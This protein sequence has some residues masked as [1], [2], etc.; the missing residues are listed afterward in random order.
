M[1]TA[2]R[3]MQ[4]IDELFKIFR[5]LGTPDETTWPGVSRYPDYKDTFP[6]W[7]ARNL[8]ELVPTLEPAGIDVLSLMLRRGIVLPKGFESTD[9]H[10]RVLTMFHH[11][12]V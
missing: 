10:A 3:W 5:V 4:E 7:P 1:L 9:W 6:R 12:Q 8:A 2:L 11:A